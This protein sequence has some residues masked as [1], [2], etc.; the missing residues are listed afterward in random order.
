MKNWNNNP[1]PSHE[2]DKDVVENGTDITNLYFEL[3]TDFYEV[4]MLKDL[5]FLLYP[6]TM[7]AEMGTSTKCE[8][9]KKKKTLGAAQALLLEQ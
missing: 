2:S 1:S 5:N 8:N 7:T 3:S 6:G 4:C 9:T